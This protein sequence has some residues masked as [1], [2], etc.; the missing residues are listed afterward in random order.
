MCLRSM[1]DITYI[2]PQTF[3]CVCVCDFILIFLPQIPCSNDTTIPVTYVPLY[4][5]TQF[6]F[7]ITLDK[8]SNMKDLMAKVYETI[9]SSQ[10]YQ[11]Y[12]DVR[13][14]LLTLEDMCAVDV[15]NSDVYSFY[16]MG[17]SVDTIN[18]TDTP[19]VYQLMPHSA[20]TTC[21]VEG[22][23]S[24]DDNDDGGGDNL[25]AAWLA[26][27]N[28]H[29]LS[30]PEVD[31]MLSAFSNSKKNKTSIKISEQYY[32]ILNNALPDR[33]LVKSRRNYMET[34]QY[35]SRLQGHIKEH[36]GVNI[37]M[38]NTKTIL[39]SALMLHSETLRTKSTLLTILL[40]KTDSP[41]TLSTSGRHNNYSSINSKYN[42]TTCT[43]KVGVQVV[44]I[45]PN[46]TVYGLRKMMAE[47]VRRGWVD[48]EEGFVKAYEQEYNDYVAATAA[49]SVVQ[50]DVD[51]DNDDYD[52]NS[53]AMRGMKADGRPVLLEV[54][55]VA[56]DAKDLKSA[57]N[58]DD[59]MAADTLHS[60]ST[61]SDEEIPP[62]ISS[63]QCTAEDSAPSATPACMVSPVPITS[64]AL[65]DI[66]RRLPLTYSKKNGGSYS[67][68]VFSKQLGCVVYDRNENVRRSDVM[69]SNNHSRSSSLIDLKTASEEEEGEDMFVSQLVG[70]NGTVQVNIPPSLHTYM[71][72]SVFSTTTP[73]QDD[74]KED[75]ETKGKKSDKITLIDCI[76]AFTNREQLSMSESYYCSTCKDHV[77]AHKQCSVYFAPN[78]LVVHLKRF[79]FSSVS[80][81][82]DKIEALVDYPVRGLDLRETVMQQG[83]MPVADHA[84][85][86]TNST[87]EKE[88]QQQHE[89]EGDQLPPI[90]D[91]QAVSNHYGGLGGGH[92]TAYAKR[93]DKW[94]HFDD[95][96][97]TE[98]ENEADVV[99]SAGY[100][101]YYVR[102]GVTAPDEMSLRHMNDM[103]MDTQNSDDS[104]AMICTSAMQVHAPNSAMSSMMM[105]EDDVNAG[106]ACDYDHRFNGVNPQGDGD[107]DGGTVL[108]AEL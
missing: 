18:S 43:K 8:S 59:S 47:C 63:A 6:T 20:A 76:E 93:D 75:D 21:S 54:D 44:R 34:I 5:T 86:S 51:V 65:F 13:T 67:S 95:S 3:V 37:G 25:G 30:L 26:Q 56:V 81:R 74:D 36:K 11:Q 102:R 106:K 23:V 41:S 27:S 77:Q 17:D 62:L 40:Q 24:G 50:D 91:L 96:R 32:Q 16:N 97:V 108:L 78:V 49:V 98:I 61:T 14:P 64:N 107:D 55:A 80:H 87:S 53:A 66:Y 33:I 22:E 94:Y 4:S 99:T 10:Q 35:L 60:S 15:Y 52:Y 90:Y 68:G 46:T 101:L 79:Y 100:V 84:D 82:R 71:D 85:E 103:N 31:A 88:K 83:S 58:P 48:V 70:N 19:H 29:Q 69:D 38:H 72:S 9:L 57:N 12:S 105:E 39:H 73:L 45:P 2:N 104:D 42:R 1:A 89:T 92:Y 7:K 28:L